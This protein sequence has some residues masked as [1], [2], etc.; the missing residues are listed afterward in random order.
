MKEELKENRS[1]ILEQA[2]KDL[3]HSLNALM[4]LV[5]SEEN[6]EVSE[7]ESNTESKV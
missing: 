6:G 1:K 5:I 2:V 4:Y 7:S 3:V